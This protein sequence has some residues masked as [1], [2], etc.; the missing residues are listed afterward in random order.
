VGIWGRDVNVISPADHADVVVPILRSGMLAREF[1]R[2]HA[3]AQVEA[4]F[5]RS[6]YLRSGDDFVCVGEPDIGNGPLTL[7]GHLGLVSNLGLQPRQSVTVGDRHIAIGRSIRLTLDQSEAWR[8]PP[9]PICLSPVRLIETCAAL[10][11]RAATDAPQEGLARVCGVGETFGLEPPLARI[12][13]PRIATFERWLSAVLDKHAQDTASADAVGGLIGLGPGLTPSGDDF[14]AGAL[15]LLDC[16]G[17]RDAHAALG[18]AVIAALPGSTSPLS[19]CFLKAAAAGYIGENL[20]RAVSSV[21]AGDA[22]AAIAAVDTIG[23]SSGWDM[24][25]GIMSAL[26]TSLTAQALASA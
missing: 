11:R 8:P 25:A 19:A 13:R 18:R 16:V 7:I 2:R 3:R 14:L 12:G 23:H 26:R 10:E 24:L 6:F 20:H 17:E 9:W 21:M 15:A 1:C 5:E 22:G 4:V